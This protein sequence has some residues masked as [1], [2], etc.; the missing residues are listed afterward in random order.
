M[1]RPRLSYANVVSS[2]ALFIALGGTGYAVTQLPR[3]SVGARQLKPN[4]VTSAKIRAGAVQRSDLSP[5]ARIG[6]RGV[7][8]P[9][10]P[11]GPSETIQVK[12]AEAA[13]IPTGA[14]GSATLATISVPAGSWVFN[15][16]T[17]VVYGG[18]GT[19]EFFDCY[20][21]RGGG[22]RLGEGTLNVGEAPPS[23]IAGSIP[24]QV[25]ATFGAPT[26]VSYVCTHP[27]PIGGAPRA[28]RTVLLA[29]RVGSLEDR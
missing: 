4:A 8:G 6:S 16:Q 17:R 28:E 15:A 7:R 22:E 5:N 3:N 11:V 2:L 14:N 20:L 24:T 13:A 19:S 12:R 23:V 29:T 10:G 26:Q 1:L 18:T 27:S 25:A 9:A 21:T